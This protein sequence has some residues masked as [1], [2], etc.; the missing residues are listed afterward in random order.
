MVPLPCFFLN[1]WLVSSS[2]WSVRLRGDLVS[3]ENIIISG[4][5]DNHRLYDQSIQIIPDHFHYFTQIFLKD[6]MTRNVR[7]VFGL[8]HNNSLLKQMFFSFLI[9]SIHLCIMNLNQTTRLVFYLHQ[10]NPFFSVFH[11]QWPECHHRFTLVWLTKILSWSE[12]TETLPT[13]NH[14]IETNRVKNN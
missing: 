13:K 2:R 8:F 12:T 11:Q 3:V 4:T 5:E 9:L 6:E 10:D 14:S 1:C 7:G